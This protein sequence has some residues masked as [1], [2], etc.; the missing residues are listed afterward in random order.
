MATAL[1]VCLLI[2]VRGTARTPPLSGGGRGAGNRGRT[3]AVM[4]GRG[5]GGGSWR[6][7]REPRG[8]RRASYTREGRRL[9]CTALRTHGS[10]VLENSDAS[11]PPARA[12]LRDSAPCSAQCPG[13]GP[14]LLKGGGGENA[15]VATGLGTRRLQPARML[16]ARGSQASFTP[17]ASLTV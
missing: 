6:A 13:E 14:G 7:C 10:P 12:P 5:V 11:P 16:A 15:H 8:R 9:S 4:A 2:R 3:A 17:E 1:G